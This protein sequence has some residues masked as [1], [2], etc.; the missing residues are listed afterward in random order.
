MWRVEKTKLVEVSRK[1]NGA[2]VQEVL[3]RSS[4]WEK[5]EVGEA[6]SGLGVVTGDDVGRPRSKDQT[7]NER[8]A[9]SST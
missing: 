6:A 2:R 3:G 8:E 7:R 9:V 5:L 4:G 1:G